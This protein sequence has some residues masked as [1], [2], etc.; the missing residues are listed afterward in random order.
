MARQ[1]VESLL[2]WMKDIS[3]LWGWDALMVVER[4]TVSELLHQQYLLKLSQGVLQVP[5]GS[6]TI[7][8]SNLSH[9]FAEF[10]L[11]SPVFDL[12]NASLQSSDIAVHL[13][14]VSGMHTLLQTDLGV[15]RVLRLA[16]YGPLNGPSLSMNLQPRTG[17]QSVQLDLQ[18]GTDLLLHFAGTDIEQREAGKY[19]QAWLGDPATEG[20]VYP[21]GSFTYRD[22]ALLQV[23]RVDV[24]FQLEGD[25]KARSQDPKGAMLLFVTMEHGTTGAF[26][27]DHSDFHYLIPSDAD[28][29]Y[30][31]TVVFGSH[32]LHR[33]A[34]GDTV[35]QLLEAGEFEFEEVSGEP[36]RQMVARAGSFEVRAGRA[37][38]PQ[39]IFES[40]AF[41]LDAS[42]GQQPLTVE[43]EDSKASQSWQFPCTVTFK[44]RPLDSTTWRHHTATFD[45]SLKH[46][47][48]LTADDSA[49]HGME[50]H[51]F[52][53]STQSQEVVA[54]AGLPE[55]LAPVEREQ[56]NGFIGFTIKRALLE[57]FSQ[58]L[59]VTA[60]EPF[61]TQWMLAGGG[62]FSPLRVALPLDLV[63]FGRIR[64]VQSTFAIVQQQQVLGAGRRLSFTTEPFRENVHWSLETPPGSG[65][66]PGQI[67]DTLG[68]YRAPP[69]H[70]MTDSV[71]RVLVLARDLDTSENSVALVTIVADPI[72]INPLIQMCDHD[73]RVKLSAS[74]IDEGE[75]LWSIK[76]PV[77]GESGRVVPD[78]DPEGDHVYIAGPRVA[79]KTY[80]LDEIE[81]SQGGESASAWVLVLQ[82]TPGLVVRIIADEALPEGQ[83][84]LQALLN[85]NEMPEVQW[86][87]PAGGPGDI[88]EDTG[89]Y[90]SDSRA[91]DRFA[92]IFAKVDGGDFGL[93]EGHMILPLPLDTSSDVFQ[94]L[95][96]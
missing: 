41:S 22:N 56:I 68:A 44:Y 9:H 52:V 72:G 1:S 59:T 25:S 83:V 34:F 54:V 76:N 33:A 49:A 3:R 63:Q 2:A 69:A 38:G 11:G 16:T 39:F 46:E 10:A 45:V 35:M 30:S 64:G 51:L 82:H 20:Q 86:H 15:S 31:A 5:N 75:L 80:V 18:Q 93:F 58:T 61:L 66:D 21:L 4:D 6:A 36:L 94:A 37:E 89:I 57:A 24:R 90:H 29:P 19:F 17:S 26:P 79:G 87:L 81:V 28:Q 8:D 47:F 23:R 85:D 48:H 53:P 71:Q 65:G 32:L 43:F 95:A 70:A 77:A 78:D 40:E 13:P 62:G 91:R 92:V 27:D 96:R 55:D 67:D 12:A 7:P 60:T 73:Q 50:G 42:S 14:V 84:R 74:S 88:E